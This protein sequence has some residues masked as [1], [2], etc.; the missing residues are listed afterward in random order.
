MPKVKTPTAPVPA[1]APAE[2][3]AP[4]YS[5][6]VAQLKPILSEVKD[7]EDKSRSANLDLAIAIREFREENPTAERNECRLS[8]Q[9]AVAEQYGLKISQVQDGD[10]KGKGYSAYTLVSAI[11]SVAWPKG[12]KEE[13][14]VAKALKE[15]KGWVELR[16]AASKPQVK[17]SADPDAK[18]ITADNFATKL[19]NF[20]T[21]AQVDIGVS[22]ED[23]LEMTESAIEAIRSAPPEPAA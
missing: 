9:T 17:R 20:L 11:M 14:K 8:I 10:K 7:L 1:T 5:I 21:Q 18:R 3:A 12:D 13:N 19:A 2:A 6:L 22:I 15:G 16:K 23:I 4:D